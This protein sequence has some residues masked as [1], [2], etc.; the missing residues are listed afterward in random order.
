MSW[1]NVF[2]ASRRRAAGME[3]P[4]PEGELLTYPRNVELVPYRRADGYVAACYWSPA[5]LA[6]RDAVIAHVEAGHPLR[7]GDQLALARVVAADR[8]GFKPTKAQ[9]D[10]YRLACEYRDFQAEQWD[11]YQRALHP[12]ARRINRAWNAWNRTGRV[13]PEPLAWNYYVP[14]DEL[15]DVPD[16]PSPYLAYKKEKAKAA[17]V[18]DDAIDKRIDARKKAHDAVFGMG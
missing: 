4:R 18:S 17:G 11:A 15:P 16:A 7:V 13:G 14:G 1:E 2:L 6:Y 12:F 8:D 3:V 9:C 5:A 10:Q